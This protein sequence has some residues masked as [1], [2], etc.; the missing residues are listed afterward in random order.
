MEIKELHFEEIDSTSSFIKRNWTS[1][2][3]FTFVSSSFQ[4]EGRGRNDRKWLSEKGSSLLFSL[5]IKDHPLLNYGPFLS[6]PSAVS[7][8]EF[9]E[10]EGVEGVSI[11]WPNDIYIHGKKVAGI[12]LE[13][14]LPD[15][16]IIGIGI[17]LNQ[18][19]FEGE[20]RRP[21]TSI[22]L[23]TG[24]KVDVS[25]FKDG[26]FQAIVETFLKEDMKEYCLSYF[27][28]H[29]FLLGKRGYQEKDKRKGT[30]LG[31]DKDFNLLFNVDNEIL[32]L[33]S[34]EVSAIE[35]I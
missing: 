13:G 34:G 10:K 25:S 14:S 19:S 5:L 22:F 35:I 8:S 3:P 7:I 32:T 6:L 2:P 1:L 12:L 18:P 20:Y 16:L 31:V 27:K 24:K 21:P 11:K 33:S 26:L 4:K 9:L 28:T 23:E 30:F 29:D 17:N 15:Y